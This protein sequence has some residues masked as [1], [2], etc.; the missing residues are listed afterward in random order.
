MKRKNISE[1]NKV[2]LKNA[3][4][5]GKKQDNHWKKQSKLRKEVIENIYDMC[6]AMGGEIVIDYEND[7]CPLIAYDGGRHIEYNSTLCAAVNTIRAIEKNGFKLFQ[8]DLEEEEEYDCDRIEFPD[9]CQIFDFVYYKFDEWLDDPDKDNDAE[10]N[11][12]GEQ[13]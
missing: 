9:I 12:I 10:T 13:D 3:K 1:A 8:V 5:F 2:L 7:D 11:K 6:K 4:K